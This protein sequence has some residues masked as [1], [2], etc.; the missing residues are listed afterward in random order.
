MYP[1]SINIIHRP[2][3]HM[4]YSSGYKLFYVN[5]RQFKLLL[6]GKHKNID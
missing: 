2:S 6:L 5:M 3:T 4:T 1:K